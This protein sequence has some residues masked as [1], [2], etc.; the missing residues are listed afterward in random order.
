MYPKGW[1]RKFW[2]ISLDIK[3]NVASAIASR[4]PNNILSELPEVIIS[5]I[6]G[7]VFT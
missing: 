1:Q 4:N 3:T 6:R 7:G 2:T 5:T